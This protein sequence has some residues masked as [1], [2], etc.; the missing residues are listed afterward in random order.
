MWLPVFSVDF[1]TCVV[2]YS[3]AKCHSCVIP[4]SVVR[5]TKCHMNLK[6][7]YNDVSPKVKVADTESTQ[8]FHMTFIYFYLSC[9]Q[10]SH[11]QRPSLSV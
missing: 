6:I 7:N 2:L 11:F 5:R 9:R 8:G 4:H 1:E 3:T 10:T